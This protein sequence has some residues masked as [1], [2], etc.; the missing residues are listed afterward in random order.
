MNRRGR[1]SGGVGTIGF[2]ICGK[3]KILLIVVSPFLLSLE[4]GELALLFLQVI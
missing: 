4:D 2:A 1:V 3:Q